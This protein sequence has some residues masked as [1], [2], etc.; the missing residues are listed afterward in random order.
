MIVS[1]LAS[2]H[3]F[4]DAVAEK[5]TWWQLIRNV[6]QSSFTNQ[7]ATIPLALQDCTHADLYKNEAKVQEYWTL[8][9]GLDKLDQAIAI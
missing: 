1:G 7:I 8:N 4:H 9:D 5:N 6:C 2:G 3:L